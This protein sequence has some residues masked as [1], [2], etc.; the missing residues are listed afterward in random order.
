MDARSR[1][2]AVAAL[3]VAA[4]ATGPALAQQPAPQ[5]FTFGL[6]G[7]LAYNAAQEPLLDNVLADLNRTPMAFV[8]HVGDLGSPR[9]GS[10]TGRAVGAPARPVP[11]LRPSP[12][13]HAR[14]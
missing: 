13:L 7:D 9:A 11:R 12:D 4:V 3:L 6:F 10:C 1:R 8:V 14:R 2:Y 5:D